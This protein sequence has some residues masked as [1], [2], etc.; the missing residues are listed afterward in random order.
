M[1]NK[2]ILLSWTSKLLVSNEI[3]IMKSANELTRFYRLSGIM[4]P[5]FVWMH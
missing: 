5:N 4:D 3:L 2:V 1:Y